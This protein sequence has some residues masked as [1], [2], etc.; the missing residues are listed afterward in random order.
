MRGFQSTHNKTASVAALATTMLQSLD[1]TK[2][3]TKVAT[4]SLELILLTLL[5]L[6]GRSHLTDTQQT[7]QEQEV[8]LKLESVRKTAMEVERKMAVERD[9]EETRLAREQE[10]SEDAWKS[11]I[12]KGM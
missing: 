2:S 6:G 10:D 8:K 1:K 3:E 7:V 12:E 5:T 9:K 11:R 4:A